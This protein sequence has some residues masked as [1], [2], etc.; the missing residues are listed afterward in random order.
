MNRLVSDI[1][2]EID[3]LV[4]ALLKEYNAKIINASETQLNYYFA[5]LGSYRALTMLYVNLFPCTRY[6]HSIVGYATNFQAFFEQWMY[7]TIYKLIIEDIFCTYTC[8]YMNYY[9]LERVYK[10]S[11]YL[12]HLDLGTYKEHCINKLLNYTMFSLWESNPPAD[13]FLTLCA[14]DNASLTT[15]YESFTYEM[16]RDLYT[17]RTSFKW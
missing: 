3:I 13:R 17:E 15:G 1:T 9:L 11:V 7:R 14:P 10:N 8:G 12:L 2:L 5:E 16:C 6:K 4:E